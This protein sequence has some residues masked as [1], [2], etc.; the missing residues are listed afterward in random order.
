[1]LPLH[2]T[3]A[4]G[5]RAAQQLKQGKSAHELL[6]AL[7]ERLFHTEGEGETA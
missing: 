5:S 4:D 7:N 1:M 6:E 2:S 3:S